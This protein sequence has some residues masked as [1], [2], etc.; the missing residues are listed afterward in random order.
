MGRICSAHEEMRNA[1]K[2]LIGSS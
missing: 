1:H 2:M